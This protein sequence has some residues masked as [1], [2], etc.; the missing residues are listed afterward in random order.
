VNGALL[1]SAAALVGVDANVGDGCDCVDDVPSYD[2]DAE[3]DAPPGLSCHINASCSFVVISSGL[4]LLCRYKHVTL[5]H[6]RPFNHVEQ[7]FVVPFV[8]RIGGLASP[9]SVLLSI[10]LIASLAASLDLYVTYAAYVL[11]LLSL[12][13]VLLCP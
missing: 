13:V 1:E 10:C 4:A 11:P 5:V 3:C 12:V 8:H 2:D 9:F 6:C 7:Y